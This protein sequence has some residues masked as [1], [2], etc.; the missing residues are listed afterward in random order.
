MTTKQ[1]TVQT[2]MSLF[3]SINLFVHQLHS[4]RCVVYVIYQIQRSDR[5]I[6]L[7]KKLETKNSFY[8][9][10]EVTAIEVENE[11]IWNGR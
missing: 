1:Q 7:N 8:F 11:E 9:S 5:Q 10:T 2:K 4:K 3:F 6:Q